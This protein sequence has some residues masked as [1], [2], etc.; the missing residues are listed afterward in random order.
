[1][2]PADARTALAAASRDGHLALRR[3]ER[4]HA[5][6]GRL[7]RARGELVQLD[8]LAQELGVSSRTIGRDVERLRLSGVPLTVKRGPAGGV[9]LPRPAS[10][11]PISFD[12]A[13]V[14]ALMSSLTVLG[15]TATESAASAMRKLAA[16]LDPDPAA[17]ASER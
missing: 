3:V 17:D 15:P 8:E 9:R 6:L 10:V 4:Q 2:D 5:L 1:M 11:P 13:E 16:A 14:A 12:L 7:Q